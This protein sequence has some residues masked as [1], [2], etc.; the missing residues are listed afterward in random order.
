MDT[1]HY[2][3]SASSVSGW[4]YSHKGDITG[5]FESKEAAIEAA[6]AEAGQSED[7]DVEVMVRD[8]DMKTQSVWR[9]KK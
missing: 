7:T 4:Q 9:G 3:V 5:P 8:A 2:V 1:S 6:I